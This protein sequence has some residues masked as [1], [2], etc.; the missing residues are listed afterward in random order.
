MSAPDKT[1]QCF[2]TP[3]NCTRLS[4][5]NRPR[6]CTP[7]P[8]HPLP[9]PHTHSSSSGVQ[10]G[11]P[12]ELFD[13]LTLLLFLITSFLGFSSLKVLKVET[14]CHPRQDVSQQPSFNRLFS[15]FFRII[16]AL[17]HDSY[18]LSRESSLLEEAEKV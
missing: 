17:H 14:C 15:S 9:P 18:D 6:L 12:D 11:L 7:D 8:R 10:N 4:S 5:V 2:I 13:C 3:Q 1:Y 16:A